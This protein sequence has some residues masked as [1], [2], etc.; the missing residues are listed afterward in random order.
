[1]K[2]Y[3][4]SE[5]IS[6]IIINFDTRWL[7][8]VT[9]KTSAKLASGK[10][11]LNGDL[12]GFRPGLEVL[13]KRISS[14]LSVNRTKFP[15]LSSPSPLHYSDHAIPGRPW[16]ANFKVTGKSLDTTPSQRDV[17]GSYI[18]MQGSEKRSCNLW[19]LPLSEINRLIYYLTIAGYF[20]A[21]LS[22]AF[23]LRY[24]CF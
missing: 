22:V 15:L 1:M 24:G 10:C 21:F 17:A 3:K 5:G 2:A 12:V 8:V 11:P 4:G 14:N 7:S 9:Y 20:K 19:I 18:H 16:A 23:D 6:P 13:E